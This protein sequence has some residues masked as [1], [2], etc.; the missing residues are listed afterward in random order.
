MPHMNQEMEKSSKDSSIVSNEDVARIKA[1]GGEVHSTETSLPNFETLNAEEREAVF[2]G[3]NAKNLE[4]A[5][6]LENP[7]APK[8]EPPKAKAEGE[9]EHKKKEG[10]RIRFSSE[11][12]PLKTETLKI[13]SDNPDMTFA[14]AEALACEKLGLP[15]QKASKKDAAKQT[16]DAEDITTD[17]T[18]SKETTI[19]AKPPEKSK[20]ILDAEAK[21]TELKEK[22]KKANEEADFDLKDQ[23]QEEVFEQ[24]LLIQD[25]TRRQKDEAKAQLEAQQKKDEAD[26]HAKREVFRKKTLDD[27]P[28]A[29]DEKGPLRQKIKE[30]TKTYTDEDDDLIYSERFPYQVALEAAAELGIVKLSLREKVAAN[31]SKQPKFAPPAGGDQTSNEKKIVP[32][33]EVDAALAKL[34]DADKQEA[35]QEGLRLFRSMAPA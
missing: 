8:E 22:I 15:P 13:I 9:E 33:E 12:T 17:K 31:S 6:A 23:L 19:E 35:I 18:L 30:L 24:K 1:A 25:E 16:S 2:A 34:S 28:E 4:A 29:S 14:D 10:P 7:K 11:L 27:F 5:K 21:I 32:K 20:L 26:F 3:I